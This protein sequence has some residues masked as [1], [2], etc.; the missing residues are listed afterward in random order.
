LVVQKPVG[1]AAV[2]KT[3]AVLPRRNQ[4]T[5]SL[6]PF[7]SLG[8]YRVRIAAIQRRK[9]VAQQQQPLHVFQQVPFSQLL[10]GIGATSTLPSGVHATL[11]AAFPFVD[12][13]SEVEGSKQ[14]IIS[15]EKNYCGLVHL[16]FVADLPEI[17]H[18][19]GGQATLTVVQER[20]E[21][22]S[23][24]VGEGTV[25]TLDAHVVPGESWAVNTSQ[26][27]RELDFYL[28]GYAVCDSTTPIS[29]L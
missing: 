20:A 18:Q 28:N 14:G 15:D 19:S 7:S 12:K 11:T 29:A 5:A 3:I 9:V 13:I 26:T 27:A 1:T 17:A 4:G 25:G 2:W 6:A 23:A 16:E 24:T 22:I 21:P 10:I 8:T